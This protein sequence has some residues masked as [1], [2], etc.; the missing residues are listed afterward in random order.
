MMEPRMILLDEP[1][2]GINPSLIEKLAG[3]IRDLNSQ[4]V[5]FLIVEHNIPMVLGLCDPVVVFSRGAAIA[6]G[7]PDT[8]RNDP[9]VLDAYLGDEWKQEPAQRW[10]RAGPRVTLSSIPGGS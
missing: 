7:H 8:I 5:S 1:A 6:E 4:G 2:G 9:A 3:V 10:S